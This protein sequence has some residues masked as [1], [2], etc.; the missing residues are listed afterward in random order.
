MMLDIGIA[1]NDGKASEG[2]SRL[3]DI[4]GA[5]PGELFF[6]V[7]VLRKRWVNR[8]WLLPLPQNLHLMAWLFLT[9]SLFV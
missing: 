3:Y 2:R 8:L 1:E 9:S 7:V 6:G 4:D 5:C